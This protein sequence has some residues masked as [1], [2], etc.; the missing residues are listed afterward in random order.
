[1]KIGRKIITF[2][3][4]AHFSQVYLR[5]HNRWRKYVHILT[6]GLNM[7]NSKKKTTPKLDEK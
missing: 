5:N 2:W 3:K 7:I 4:M 1:M 6:K